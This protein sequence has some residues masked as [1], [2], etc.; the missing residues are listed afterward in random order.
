MA[1]LGFETQN[2]NLVQPDVLQTDFVQPVRLCRGTITPTDKPKAK[3]GLRSWHQLVAA[4]LSTG[5]E[6]SDLFEP[7]HLAGADNPVHMACL[8]PAAHA[9]VVDWLVFVRFKKVRFPDFDLVMRPLHD[10]WMMAT[11]W[12]IVFVYLL[13][14][15]SKHVPSRQE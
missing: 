14:V 15:S 1:G 7:G 8:N 11:A 4:M 3:P 12:I 2:A 13:A 9:Q 10:C 5:A 6:V